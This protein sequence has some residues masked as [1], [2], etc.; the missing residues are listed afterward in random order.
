MREKETYSPRRKPR[1]LVST[2]RHN[3]FRRIVCRRVRNK[4]DRREVPCTR[5]NESM[6]DG[7]EDPICSQIRQGCRILMACDTHRNPTNTSNR[8]VQFVHLKYKVQTIPSVMI[9]IDKTYN[10]SFKHFLY[11][12]DIQRDL[13]PCRHKIVSTAGMF[14]IQV[15]TISSG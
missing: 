10:V 15:A 14:R 2:V 7:T 9:F 11:A 1:T 8:T 5:C 4:Q 3:V 6:Q 13:V 12:S